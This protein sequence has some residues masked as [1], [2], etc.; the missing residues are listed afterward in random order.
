MKDPGRHAGFMKDKE[1]L[2][3]AGPIQLVFLGDSITDF[4]RNEPQIEIYKKNFGKYNP[5]NTGLSGDETQHLLWRID[6]GEL[7]GLAPKVVT[8]MIGTNNLGNSKQTPVQTIDGVRAVVAAV[9]QKLPHTK[10]LLL[11][12][13]PRGNKADDPFRAQIKEVNATLAQLPLVDSHVM[14]LDIGPKFLTDD[15]TL[16]IYIMPDFLHPG[17]VGYQIWADAVGPVVD[18]LEK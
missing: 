8:L 18:S 2:S 7:D 12:V 16:P 5:Y 11:A 10:I 15:G 9:E 14:Y 3:K 1:A 4:W 17:P 6:H 13:F